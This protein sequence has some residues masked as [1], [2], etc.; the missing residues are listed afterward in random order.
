M[1]ESW[2]NLGLGMWL[3]SI[4]M[5]QH[6]SPGALLIAGAAAIV[7]GLWIATTRN[8]WAGAFAG[9]LGVWLYVAAVVTPFAGPR[10]YVLAGIA[11][12]LSAL[13]DLV[14]HHRRYPPPSWS[15]VDYLDHL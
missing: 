15:G 10:R 8:H 6:S 14:T 4:G 2:L 3:L 5:R 1:W 7:L 12:A 11:L 9:L 13:W